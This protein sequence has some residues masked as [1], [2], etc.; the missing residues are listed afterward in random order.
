MQELGKNAARISKAL[1]V[2]VVL[3]FLMLLVSTI[4]L[5]GMSRTAVRTDEWIAH[6]LEVKEAL[7]ALLTTITGAEAGQRGYL[8][9][10]DEAF[11]ATFAAAQQTV[12]Q[13]LEQLRQLV[14][15]DGIQG[16]RLDALVSVIDR[17]SSAMSDTLDLSRT[18]DRNE[19]AQIVR[20]RAAAAMRE[21]HERIAQMDDSEN[22]RLLERRQQA[23]VIREQFVAGI[24]ALVIV[25]GIFAI[26]ALLSVR[27]YLEGLAQSRRRLAAYHADLELKVAERTAEL[28]RSTE[29]AERERNRAETLLT[30]VNHRV[31]NNLALVSSFLAMQQRALTSPEAVNALTGARARVQAI[32]SAHRKLRL[33]ADFATVR[34][35]E[36]LGAVL[37][38]ICAGLP[39][40]GHIGVRYEL[41]PLEIQARDAVSLGVLTS[42]LVMNAVKHA[43]PGGLRG[44]VTVIFAGNGATPYLE[45]IDDGVG[46]AI[47]KNESGQGDAEETSSGLGARII[48]MVGRQFGGC[49]QRSRARDDPERPGTRVRIELPRLALAGPG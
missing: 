12:P 18:G 11:L 46:Y 39:A 33:G 6:T 13:Q 9:T 22:R 2:T 36:V 38:D 16:G 32:A 45:V 10:G 48:E 7:S 42:E 26:F 21:I 8:V 5:V 15:D 4:V 23:A 28:S 20:G 47:D 29:L 31:G 44:E 34:A 37:D 19:I 49:A 27:A 3:C 41:A 24:S 35:N 14:A 17:W 1:V 43:F 30:D 40:N 25:A